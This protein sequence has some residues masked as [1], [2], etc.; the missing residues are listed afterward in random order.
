MFSYAKKNKKWFYIALIPSIIGFTFFTVFPLFNALFLSLTSWDGLSSTKEFIGF[1]NYM[2]IFT[3]NEFWVVLS[4]TGKFVLM[5]IPLI[6][7]SSIIVALLYNRNTKSTMVMKIIMFLPVL[8]SWVAGALIWKT[9]LNY[10]F[11]LL[12]NILKIFGIQGPNWLDS[13]KWAMRSIVIVT[14]WKDLGY[15]SLIMYSGLASIDESI[16][17]AAKI[18]GA[19]GKEI[20]KSITFP[21]LTPTIF[22]VLITTLISAFQIFP[23][24]MILTGGG[25]LRSTQV[26]V[27]RIYTYGFNYYQMGYASALS[28]ILLLIIMVVTFL[29]FYLEK[30][31]VSYD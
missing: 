26:M 23:Q 25:P 28:I 31:W 8:T 9:I 22:M 29:Q 17:E 20:F 1:K 15:F 19:D 13:P 11:G 6:I 18:D 16:Y 27:E 12:N 5:Y 30:R 10:D 14:L 24:V 4:N 21:L 3:T 2:T 7:V